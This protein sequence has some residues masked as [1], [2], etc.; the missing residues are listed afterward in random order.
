MR[1]RPQQN[2]QRMRQNAQRNRRMEFHRLQQKET[3]IPP[4]TDTPKKHK[5]NE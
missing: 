4:I 1:T 3:N 5:V 2:M